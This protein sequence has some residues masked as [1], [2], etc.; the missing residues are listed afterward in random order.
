VVGALLLLGGGLAGYFIGAAD[1]HDRGRGH[2]RPG[3]ARYDDGGPGLR[4]G[5]PE[6]GFPQQRG[7]RQFVPVPPQPQQQQP[8]TNPSSIN[9]STVPSPTSAPQPPR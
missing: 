2:G 3:L 4:G 9:P 1:D 6:R 5:G 8:Q 7:G